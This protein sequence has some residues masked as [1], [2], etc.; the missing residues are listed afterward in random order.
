MH[1]L[2]WGPEVR[3]LREWKE[4]QGICFQNEYGLKCP[5]VSALT[6]FAEEKPKLHGITLPI[7]F[8]ILNF[9]GLW[10]LLDNLVIKSLSE[11]SDASVI[12]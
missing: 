5:L 12:L 10:P 2:G 3:S 6:F 1:R 8:L 7:Y 9:N 4:L 11:G